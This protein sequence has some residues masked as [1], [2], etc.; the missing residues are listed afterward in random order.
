ME[1]YIGSFGRKFKDMEEFEEYI[2]S[3][4]PSQVELE[5][6]WLANQFTTPEVESMYNLCQSA[7]IH[8]ENNWSDTFKP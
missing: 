6:K 3:L 4:A 5:F 2:R 8:I 7:L 1:N